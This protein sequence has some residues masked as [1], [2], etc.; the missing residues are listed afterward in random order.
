M[1]EKVGTKDWWDNYFSSS[2]G[3]E[4]NRGRL[5]TKVFA[6]SCIKYT[7]LD[8]S[9][10]FRLIDVG[11]ALGEAI[12]IFHENYPK[13][14][15]FGIDISIT[16]ISRCQ[17]EL[18]D[19]A[20]FEVMKI[21][22][23]LDFFHVIYISNVLE[24]F[25]DFRDKARHLI[26][27]CEKLIILVPFMELIAGK[28]LKPNPKAHH[29]HTFNLDSFDFLIKENLS[30]SINTK[31]FRCYPA[32]GWSYSRL[33]FEYII[34]YPLRVLLGKPILR[35]PRIIMYDVQSHLKR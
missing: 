4:K 26:N 11:C 6:E 12:L 35:N 30:T 7:N 32:W 8:R 18:G 29:Q 15:L 27:H 10:E 17:E 1:M 23:V 19:I 33:L 31:V 14:Q 9:Q 16:A 5:Q 13:A 2:G 21:E 34:K 3:W 24:H 20:S 28:P 25:P 22:E